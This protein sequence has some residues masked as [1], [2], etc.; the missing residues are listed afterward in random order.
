MALKG[1]FNGLKPEQD[2]DVYTSNCYAG[3]LLGAAVLRPEL[4]ALLNALYAVPHPE[5]VR[6]DLVSIFFT[7][8]TTTKPFTLQTPQGEVTVPAGT[9]VNHPAEVRPAEM[10]RLNLAVPFR[11]GVD[12]SLCSP[13]PNYKLGLLGG[14]V[15]GFPNGRRLQDDITEIELLA[16]AGA[17][18]WC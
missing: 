8:M 15:C 6:D 17:A 11:P 12:G 13:E 16:V 9:N 1:A 7:G 3:E 2:Y 18:Y 14:D 5:G 4:E 10:L